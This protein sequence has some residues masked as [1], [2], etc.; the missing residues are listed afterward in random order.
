M[1]MPN[2][3]VE[4][5]IFPSK[6][7][8]WK[9]KPQQRDAQ[10]QRKARP[11]AF[12]ARCCHNHC[13]VQNFSSQRVAKNGARHTRTEPCFLQAVNCLPNVQE[14]YIRNGN[15]SA[16]GYIRSR[17]SKASP[18]SM[19]SKSSNPLSASS[20]MSSIIPCS[21]LAQTSVVV[22]GTNLGHDRLSILP[23]N[24]AEWHL[25]AFVLVKFELRIVDVGDLLERDYS[26]PFSYRR[27]RARA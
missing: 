3:T 11:A 27:A 25:G 14:H 7:R 19:N 22:F 8:S 16:T 12:A 4:K 13:D 18:S 9:G 23:F 24:V 5:L 2:G 10:E 1:R 20:L 6:Q 21:S 17:R 26:G 15:D